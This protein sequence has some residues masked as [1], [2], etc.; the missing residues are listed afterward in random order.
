LKDPF[1][2]AHRRNAFTLAAAEGVPGMT[3]A[4]RRGPSKVNT[5]FIND[6]S[7]SMVPHASPFVVLFSHKST[8]F[9][10]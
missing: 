5:G 6:V 3:H 2:L 7:A 1:C 8:T 9:A 10:D 4:A